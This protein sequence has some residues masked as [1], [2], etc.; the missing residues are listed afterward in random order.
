MKNIK[1]YITVLGLVTTMISCNDL[2]DINVNPSFPVDVS[3]TALMPPIEQQMAVGLQ[4]DNRCLGRYIQNFSIATSGA[5][6]SEWDRFGYQSN[7]DTGGE[8][9]KMTYFAIGLNL[10]KLQEKAGSRTAP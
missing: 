10:T 2:E 3:A 8:I 1:K 4:F 9:W 5:V 7:S 6:G